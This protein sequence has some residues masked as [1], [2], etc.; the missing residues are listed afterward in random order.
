[1]SK[2]GLAQFLKI[3]HS[4]A[5]A[6]VPQIAAIENLAK[7]IP[8]LK[9]VQKATPVMEMSIQA[10]LEAEGLTDKDFVNDAKFQMG[11]RM[12]NDG[13]VLVMQSIEDR[14]RANPM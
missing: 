2:K 11:V 13:L 1:M 10:M 3:G 4:I 8:S 6:M 9:G 14:E 7:Q 5:V 12:M